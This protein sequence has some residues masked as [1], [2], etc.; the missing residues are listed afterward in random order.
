MNYCVEA[1]QVGKC[2]ITNVAETLFIEQSFW[3]NRSS[4]IVSKQPQVQSN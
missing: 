4:Q 2:D 3:Q 1:I